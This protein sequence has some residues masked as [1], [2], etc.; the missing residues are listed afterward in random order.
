MKRGK[1][2]RSARGD[3]VEPNAAN[4]IAGKRKFG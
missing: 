2:L 4:E 3:T 1:D